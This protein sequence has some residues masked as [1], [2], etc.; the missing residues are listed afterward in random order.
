MLTASHA[1]PEGRVDRVA[2]LE[3][4]RGRL[5]ASGPSLSHRRAAGPPRGG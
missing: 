5:G 4:T 1:K 2:T 3:A